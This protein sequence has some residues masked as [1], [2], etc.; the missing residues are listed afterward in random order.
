MTGST[1]SFETLG[2]G[3]FLM[4]GIFLA[5]G[6][7]RDV[8]GSLLVKK[9]L[10][11]RNEEEPDSLDPEYLFGFGIAGEDVLAGTILIVISILTVNF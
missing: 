7:I 6:G 2:Q 10:N 8:F 9:L 11:R 4:G 1:F 3:L 5:I